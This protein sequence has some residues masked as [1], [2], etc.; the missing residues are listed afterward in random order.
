MALLRHESIETTMRYY[1]GRNANT[2]ADAVWEASDRGPKRY[3][4]GYCCPKTGR[5]QKAMGQ[6]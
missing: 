2:T 1:V 5:R 3:C 4:F 6:T